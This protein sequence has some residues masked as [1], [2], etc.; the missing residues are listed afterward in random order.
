MNEERLAYKRWLR[1]LYI[2]VVQGAICMLIVVIIG[3]GVP[4]YEWRQVNCETCSHQF[5]DVLCADVI[6]RQNCK[7]CSLMMY[8]G[9]PTNRAMYD[10]SGNAKLYR[11]R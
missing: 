1:L 6:V 5:E 11:K 8:Q 9:K 4:K 7:K 2:L 10:A 3:C